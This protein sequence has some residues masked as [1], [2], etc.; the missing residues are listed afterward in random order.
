MKRLRNLL[1][2]FQDSP[3]YGRD[4]ANLFSGGTIG[5]TALLLNGA[6]LVLVL[7]LMLDPDDHEF[8]QITQNLEFGQL[9][10]MTLMGGQVSQRRY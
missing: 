1:K 2:L 10:A 4:R 5:I 3:T 9:L 8:R 6:V 7:P